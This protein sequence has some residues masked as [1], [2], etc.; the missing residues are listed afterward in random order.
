MDVQDFEKR[1]DFDY[2]GWWLLGDYPWAEVYS[3]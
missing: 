1:S 2:H 3:L